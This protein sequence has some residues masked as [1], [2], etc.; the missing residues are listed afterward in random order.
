L[1]HFAGDDER[2]VAF[3]DEVERR[4]DFQFAIVSPVDMHVFGAMAA[5]RLWPSASMARRMKLARRLRRAC[6]YLAKMERWNPRNFEARS[7][8]ARA[9]R[10]STLG[11][12]MTALDELAAAVRSARQHGDGKHESIA[13]ELMARLRRH[14]GSPADDAQALAIAAYR[15]WGAHARAAFLRTER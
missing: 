10:L 12:P 5:A 6:G 2:C 9:A 3:L 4:K 7:R 1:L 11:R 14:E 13:L 8:I 15:R